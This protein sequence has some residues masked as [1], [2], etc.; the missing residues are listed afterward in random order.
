MFTTCLIKKANNF[1]LFNYKL[2]LLRN[3]ANLDLDTEVLTC[4]NMNCKNSEHLCTLSGYARSIT[5]HRCSTWYLYLY[6]RLGLSPCERVFSHG[7]IIMHRHR[8]RLSDK[9][10]S[11]LIFLKCNKQE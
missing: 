6:L 11:N 3:L 1:D 7:G 4:H 8:A 2:V 5:D 10:L 9:L